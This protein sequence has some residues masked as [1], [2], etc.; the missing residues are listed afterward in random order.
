MSGILIFGEQSADGLD[1]ITRELI[2]V[3]R[4][5]S[6]AL[7]ASVGVALIG[8]GAADAPQDAISH[9]ADNVFVVNH[10]ILAD[11]QVDA[12]LAAFEQLCRQEQP[13]VVLFGRTEMGRDVGP[14]LAFRLGVGIAQ[15]SVQVDV[16]DGRLV[17]VRPVYGGNA[18]ARIR[19]SQDGPQ[20][21]IVRGRVYEA[22][23]TDASRSGEVTEFQPDLGADTVKARRVETIKGESEGVRL[24]DASI[25]VSGG[26]GLGG[27]DPFKLLEE[28]AD[29][30]SGAVGASR[31]V[32]DA[33]WMP[34]PY[35]VGLTG[36]TVAPDIYIAVGISGASQHMAGCSGAKNIIA[37]NR[38]AD[39]NIFKEATF[40]VVGDFN[41]VLPSFLE[42]V[43]ELV[44]S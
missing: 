22:L 9:G 28:I 18:L 4:R 23:E 19:F 33:G 35:Q 2:A 12:Q 44:S 27:P 26:R 31:A 13:S 14:R 38:D 34:H 24:E 37:I 43:R 7:F 3:G 8:P 10:D 5:V 16:E 20:I 21:A 41:N 36:K 11:G 30:L 42:A 29:L 40:G 1:G 32:C 6:D 25:V 17:V 39:A 15:D